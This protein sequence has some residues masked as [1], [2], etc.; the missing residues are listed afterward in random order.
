MNRPLS[1]YCSISDFLFPVDD[2]S[3][4]V[5]CVNDIPR[6]CL[7]CFNDKVCYILSV[8]LY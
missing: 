2:G 7:T 8:V 6:I 4:A 3:F 1:S 5:V